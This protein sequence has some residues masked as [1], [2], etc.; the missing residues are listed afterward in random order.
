MSWKAVLFVAISL[1]VGLAAAGLIDRRPA[2]VVTED[3]GFDQSAPLEDRVRAL[4]QALS[5]ERYAR[6]L[7]QDELF[8]LTAELE[9]LTATPTTSVADEAARTEPQAAAERSS[10]RLGR[11]RSQD[12]TT[13]LV[14]AG[15]SP[16]QAEAIA[17]RE[18]ELQMEALQARY[19]AGQGGDMSAFYRSRGATDES[20]RAELGEA[21]YERYRNATGQSTTVAVGS[22]IESSPAQRA[23]LQYGD[24]IVRYDGERVYG[25]SDLIRQTMEGQ[26][27][28]QVMI[29]ILRDGI[30]MQVVIPRGPLGISGGRRSSN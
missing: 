9:G 22:V 20:L 4:E 17:Q 6:Q 26:P 11:S 8:Y 29:D 15:F 13:Q 10:S 5:S 7:L 1:T 28:Q 18:A 2:V 3:S 24:R 23:G 30:P 21:D 12:R 27:G 14:L 19:D 25:M 16:S